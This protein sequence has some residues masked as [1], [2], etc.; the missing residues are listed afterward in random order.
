MKASTRVLAG[1]ATYSRKPG[2][3]STEGPPWST[4]V[5]TPEWTPTVSASRPKRPLT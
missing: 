1:L 5:V 3:V 4:T 2:K